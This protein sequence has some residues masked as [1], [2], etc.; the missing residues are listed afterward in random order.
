[1]AGNLLPPQKS[2]RAPPQIAVAAQKALMVLEASG[3]V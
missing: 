1:M 3:L 2:Q